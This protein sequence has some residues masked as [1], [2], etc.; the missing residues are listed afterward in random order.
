MHRYIRNYRYL[1]SVLALGF[2]VLGGLLTTVTHAQTINVQ[3]DEW[4]LISF[5][6]LP[7]PKEQNG[8]LVDQH[9]VSELLRGAINDGVVT[10]VWTYIP[11]AQQDGDGAWEYWISDKE[12]QVEDVPVYIPGLSID[13]AMDSRVTNTLTHI[14]Y[15]KAYWI[16]GKTAGTIEINVAPDELMPATPVALEGGWNMVGFPINKPVTYDFAFAGAKYTQIWRF[17]N[18]LGRFESIERGEGSA[19]VEEDFNQLEPGVGYWVLADHAVTLAPVLRTVLPPDT[20]ESPFVTTPPAYNF[21]ASIT[22]W[23]KDSGDVDLDNCGDYDTA[24]SQRLI[25]FGDFVNTQT[26]GIGNNTEKGGAGVLNW[27]ARIVSC[28]EEKHHPCSGGGEFNGDIS[29]VDWLRFRTS[30]IDDATGLEEFEYHNELSGTNTQIDSQIVLHA[31]RSGLLSDQKYTACIELTHNGLQGEEADEPVGKRSFVVDMDVPDL[32]GDYEMKVQLDRFIYNNEEKEIDQHNPLYFISI[33]RDGNSFKAMLDDDRSMLITQLTYMSGFDLRNPEANFQLFGRMDV[34]ARPS[35]AERVAAGDYFNPYSDKVTRE[36]SLIGRR[37]LPEDGLSP[38]DLKGEFS[39][40]IYGLSGDKVIRLEGRFTARRLNDEPKRKDELT[41]TDPSSQSVGLGETQILSIDVKQRI[42][43]SEFDV[44]INAEG[45]ENQKVD[46]SLF[47]PWVGN[48]ENFSTPAEIQRGFTLVQSGKESGLLSGVRFPA[49][50][51][52]VESLADLHGQVAAGTWYLRVKNTGATAG[53]IVNWS[54]D[55]D[56][57]NRYQA[58]IEVDAQFLGLTLSLVGCGVNQSAVAQ[59]HTVLLV[60]GE[61]G[62]VAGQNK[63]R[64]AIAVIF[65][66]LIPCEYTV[67]VTSLGFPD[68]SFDLNVTD[69]RENSVCLNADGYLTKTEIDSS[70]LTPVNGNLEVLV[71]PKL[72]QLIPGQNLRFNVSVPLANKNNSYTLKMFRLENGDTSLGDEVASQAYSHDNTNVIVLPKTMDNR[73]GHYVISLYLEGESG[74]SAS[75]DTLVVNNSFVSIEHN[76][77]TSSIQ[78]QFS[79]VGSGGVY[80]ES[81]TF[82]IDRPDHPHVPNDAKNKNNDSDCFVENYPSPE[83]S[84]AGNPYTNKPVDLNVSTTA[85]KCIASKS[86]SISAENKN[87]DASVLAEESGNQNYHYLINVSI[88]QPFVGGSSY[89]SLYA[90]DDQGTDSI[91][92]YNYRLDTGIQTTDKN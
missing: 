90:P 79:T 45:F 78:I 85:A 73:E 56:G 76:G 11:P 22:P 13:P 27:T 18:E 36:F 53:N 91:K 3:K 10:S 38:K 68:Y 49:D 63:T 34:P 80:M 21:G 30:Y 83:D 57:T 8:Q 75:S 12:V 52:P 66:N 70:D 44:F 14:Q 28:Q 39:E 37:G 1:K 86:R 71:S 4:H 6:E 7:A 82:D 25:S 72:T 16:R 15:G 40:N 35:E 51:E 2:S 84:F 81:A 32:V 92:R 29:N 58:F 55:I 41:A 59:T 77:Q 43:I 65:D 54:L 61:D 89:G 74:I 26:I 87:I 46:I 31:N 48:P 64:E 20:D 9:T 42:A 47:P 5:H 62:Y 50:R 33:L 60:P 19:V 67:A 17:N 69:C 24:Y 23:A 88:G